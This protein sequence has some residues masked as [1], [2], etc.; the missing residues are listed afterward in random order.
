MKRGLLFFCVALLVFASTTFIS[1]AKPENTPKDEVVYGLLDGSGNLESITVV[2]GFALEKDG[3]VSDYGDYT[4]LQN[5]SSDDQIS[6]SGNFISF[7]G[8][9]GRVNYQGELQNR[10][11]PWTVVIEYFL[12]GQPIGPEA[13][14]GKSG[15]LKIAIKTSRNALEKGDFFEDFSLQIS[16]PMQMDL[17]KDIKTTGATI[18]DNGSTRQLSYVVLPGENGSIIINADVADFEMEPITM[19]GIRMTF[20]LPLDIDQIDQDLDQLVSAAEK[21]DNGALKLLKG[22]KALKTGMQKYTDGFR[23]LNSKVGELKDGANGLK[24]GISDLEQG[25]LSLTN[26]GAS[27]RSGAQSI[28]QSVFDGANAQL[29]GLG[30]PTLTPENYKAVLSSLPASPAIDVLINQLDDIT[31]FVAGVDEYTLGTTQLAQGASALKEGADDLSGG[32]GTLADGLQLLYENALDLNQGL[33]TFLEGV[34]AYRSGTEKFSFGTS[35]MEKEFGSQLDSLVDRLS[36]EGEVY[37]SY[38]S[39]DNSNVNFVQFVM[40]TAGISPEV[41]DPKVEPKPAEKNLWEKFLDL[42]R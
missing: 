6:K 15:E 37:E 29:A 32:I 10:Q 33:K 25:L 41:E 11:L 17:C 3:S 14:D 28:Q 35:E 23:Q 36:N 40:K 26:Q 18:A 7:A 42:F 19:A 12:N 2:N 20:D 4:S 21:M 1:G 22:A 24:N 8:K 13:L 16:V 9:A 5:L 38:V 30:V 31:S 39:D 34:A 27:L